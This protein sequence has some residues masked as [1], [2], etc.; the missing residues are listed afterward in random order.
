MKVFK[1]SRPFFPLSMRL[2][3]SHNL[4]LALFGD[5]WSS[6]HNVMEVSLERLG[7]VVECG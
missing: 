4:V 3:L 6:W 2:N 5:M 7:V 1:V